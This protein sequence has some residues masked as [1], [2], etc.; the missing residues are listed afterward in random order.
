MAA[1]SEGGLEPE[2]VGGL[3]KLPAHSQQQGD[4][5]LRAAASWTSILP[6]A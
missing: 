2:P 6:A 5:D 1:G 4:G 3:W